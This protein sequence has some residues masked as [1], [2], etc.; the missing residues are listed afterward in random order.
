MKDLNLKSAQEFIQWQIKIN[1]KAYDTRSK[2]AT[3]NGE[4]PEERFGKRIDCEEKARK[5]AEIYIG[6]LISD[7]NDKDYERLNNVFHGGNPYSRNIFEEY[8]GISL[9]KNNASTQDGLKKFIGENKVKSI[10]NEKKAKDE[11]KIKAK[12]EE[13]EKA[14]RE[15]YAPLGTFG[16]ALSPREKGLALK[17]LSKKWNVAGEIGPLLE[18]I[19]DMVN[20]GCKVKNT[21]EGDRIYSPDGFFYDGLPKIAVKFARYVEDERRK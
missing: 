8:T 4:N 13:K 21:P 2:W 3:D 9:G 14:D 15:K 16:D 7:I 11:A 17:I 5:N 19:K 1:L 20:S 10:L 12:K 6:R 18:R